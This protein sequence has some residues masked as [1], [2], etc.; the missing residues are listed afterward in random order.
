MNFANDKVAIFSDSSSIARELNCEVKEFAPMVVYEKMLDKT[1]QN[2]KKILKWNK[3]LDNA[4][5][6][7]NLPLIKTSL[8]ASQLRVYDRKPYRLLSTQI[9]FNPMILTLTQYGDRKNMLI[10]NSIDK[11]D[12][13]I[14]QYS[15]IL[16]K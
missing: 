6:F 1:N 12:P 13:K 10:A 7:M 4:S 9:N 3:K 5:I 11:I 2:F 8:L 14:T 16:G 15:A